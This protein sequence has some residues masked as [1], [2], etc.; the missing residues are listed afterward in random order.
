M[1]KHLLPN[2]HAKYTVPATET[3][4]T[5]IEEEYEEID[6]SPEGKKKEAVIKIQRCWRHQRINKKHFNFKYIDASLQSTQSNAEKI[7]YIKNKITGDKIYI[8]HQNI[9]HENIQKIRNTEQEK[10]AVDTNI[11]KSLLKSLTVIETLNTKRDQLLQRKTSF[12][13]SNK[14]KDDQLQKLSIILDNSLNNAMNIM[15]VIDKVATTVDANTIYNG[16]NILIQDDGKLANE[17]AEAV[18]G[19]DSLL[20]GATFE[21]VN[22]GAKVCTRFYVDLPIAKKVGIHRVIDTLVKSFSFMMEKI[23]LKAKS[24]EIVKKTKKVDFRTMVANSKLI[25][26]FS[27]KEH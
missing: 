11:Q 19:E 12:L 9:R 18:R 14:K 6:T 20:L 27:I 17:I 10:Y 16:N 23:H 26:S 25:S 7:D 24:I 4:K 21:K 15:H 1:N 3:N 13:F 8:R 22:D 2:T 5:N